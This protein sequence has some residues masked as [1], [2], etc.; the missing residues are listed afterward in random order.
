MGPK[1]IFDKTIGL[2]KDRFGNSIVQ[3]TEQLDG[4]MPILVILKDD[5]LKVCSFLYENPDCYYDYLACLTA[6]DNGTE[7]GTIDIIYNLYSI[8]HEAKFCLKVVLERNNENEKLPEIESVSHIWRTANWHEREAFDLMGI[9]FL[10]HPDLRRIL[11]PADWEGYPLRKDYR[12]QEYYHNIKV[13][14]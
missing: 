7:A 6:I 8:S 2:L 9:K 1:I 13:E 10:N 14:Y 5:L 11:M 3:K 4:L 12:L